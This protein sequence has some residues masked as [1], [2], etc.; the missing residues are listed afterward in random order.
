MGEST[1]PR[2]EVI[3]K[4]IGEAVK[5]FAEMCE[6][7]GSTDV[8]KDE[9]ADPGTGDSDEEEDDNDEGIVFILRDRASRRRRIGSGL[10]RYYNL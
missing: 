4:E 3:A 7:A 8:D 10:G 1:A 9:Q 5:E 2:L 6:V